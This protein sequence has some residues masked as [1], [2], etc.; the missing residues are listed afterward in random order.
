MNINLKDEINAIIDDAL[1]KAK[2]RIHHSIAACTKDG[3]VEI[4]AQDIR[5]G[6]DK[7]EVES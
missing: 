2:D 3:L 5:D 7:L 4:M 1:K 6:V